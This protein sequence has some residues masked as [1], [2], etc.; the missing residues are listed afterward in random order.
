MIAWKGELE[1]FLLTFWYSPVKLWEKDYSEVLSFC[2]DHERH[3][4]T[5]EP[6]YLGAFPTHD[7]QAGDNAYFAFSAIRVVR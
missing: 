3:S 6:V 4:L 5:L 2:E 7:V 1:R